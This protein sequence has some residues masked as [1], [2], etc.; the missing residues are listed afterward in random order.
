MTNKTVNY[1][2]SGYARNKSDLY[3]TPDWVYEALREVEDF[4]GG[5]WDCAPV[6]AAFDFLKVHKLR[7]S[8]IVTNPPFSLADE[9]VAHALALTQPHSGKVAMLLPATWDC[10]RKR[11]YRFDVPFKCKYI[12]CRRIRWENLE[13]KKNGPMHTHAWYVWDWA[14]EGP[15]M[16][17]HIVK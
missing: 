11:T 2:N 9:F 17:D 16:F 14:Y 15:R 1:R 13:Q 10:A 6:D 7:A 3:V 8:N 5:E 4:P 12:V